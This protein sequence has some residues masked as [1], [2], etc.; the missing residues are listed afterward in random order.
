MLYLPCFTEPMKKIIW[1]QIFIV[2]ASLFVTLLAT[3]LFLMESSDRR[4]KEEFEI[5]LNE[6]KTLNGKVHTFSFSPEYE[7]MDELQFSLQIVAPSDEIQ[8]HLI[9]FLKD[10]VAVEIKV[11]SQ[12][13]SESVV[14]T[15]ELKV[16]LADSVHDVSIV[17]DNPLEKNDTYQLSLTMQQ[18]EGDRVVVLPV[19]DDGTPFLRQIYNSDFFYAPITTIFFN[20]VSLVRYLKFTG[21]LLIT[22]FSTLPLLMTVFIPNLKEK[23]YLM[24]N[25]VISISLGFMASILIML[26]VNVPF[27]LASLFISSLTLF[28]FSAIILKLGNND[29]KN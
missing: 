25:I 28:V 22:L 18:Y 23:I 1:K 29:S 6:F 12:D 15:K 5:Q 13:D 17:F 26:E 14:Y 27:S 11:T 16:D 19:A 21:L 20:L 3:H 8:P 9:S 7:L 24:Q 2:L 10:K 4:F